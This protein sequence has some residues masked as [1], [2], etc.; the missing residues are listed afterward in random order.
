MKM[1]LCTQQIYHQYADVPICGVLHLY[2]SGPY[3]RSG[4]EQKNT[5]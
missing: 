3:R 4:S 5:F 2:F 1:S